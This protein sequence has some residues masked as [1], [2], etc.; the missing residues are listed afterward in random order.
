MLESSIIGKSIEEIDTPALLIDLDIMEKNLK[1]MA[2]FYKKT[3][4]AALRPHQKGHRL[5]LV[6]KKQIDTGASGVSI[7]ALGLAEYYVSCGIE[8]ILITNEIE[9]TNKMRRVCTLSKLA[10]VTVG[11][12]NMEN[13]KHF[14]A[15][16][17]EQN[18]VVNVGVELYMGTGTCGVQVET[19]LPF[20]KELTTIDH[21]NFNGL[22]WHQG[23]LADIIEWDKRKEVHFK[24]LNNIA[25][26]KDSLEDAGIDVPMVSGGFTCTWDITP[27]HPTLKEV[28]VQAGSY[29]FSDW[30]SHESEGLEV[31]DYALTVLSRC[32]SR[33]QSD[34]ALLDAGMNACSDEHTDS[35]R[36]VVGFRVKGVKGISLVKQREELSMVKFESPY[37]EIRVGD[38]VELIPPHSDTTAKLHD[39]YY[40][41]RKGVVEAVWPNL[42]RGLL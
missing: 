33:P 32:I 11:V 6:A 19:A 38:T 41:V 7:T 39:T 1:T 8:N 35:Y 30:C 23:S 26:L 2:D 21:I 25:V 20:I 27:L 12:D 15:I 9:G 37:T 17:G 14:G 29:V 5:P 31:F 4:G 40:C 22:W 18:T 13:I 3:P 42:G 36:D 34:E 24:T 28:E 10:D 16:A